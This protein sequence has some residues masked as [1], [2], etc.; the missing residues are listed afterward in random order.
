M[1]MHH[2]HAGVGSSRVRACVNRREEGLAARQSDHP[3]NLASQIDRNA[4]TARTRC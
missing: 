3:E 2:T 1:A 4:S